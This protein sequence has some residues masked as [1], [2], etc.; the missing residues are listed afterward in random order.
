MSKGGGKWKKQYYYLSD[1]VLTIFDTKGGKKKEEIPMWSVL[2][3]DHTGKEK[4]RE[5]ARSA[6]GR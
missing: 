4:E 3:K 2:F 1:G 6:R 5:Q